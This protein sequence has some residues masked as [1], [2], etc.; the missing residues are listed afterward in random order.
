M[1]YY[2]VNLLWGLKHYQMLRFVLVKWNGLTSILATTDLT[3]KPITVIELYARRAKIESM[4]QEMK[5]QLGGFRYH[6]WTSSMPKLN[7]Y[8][9]KDSPDSLTGVK[10]PQSRKRILDCIMA[11]ENFVTCVTV[12]M[13]I[14]QLLSMQE[15]SNGS[16]RKLRYL[17]T[18]S[19]MKPSEG[20]V[21]YYIR[22]NLF[23]MLLLHP[24]SF[25]TRFIRERQGEPSETELDLES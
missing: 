24:N 25:I 8:A 3:M 7:H 15:Y 19:K 23:S 12:A 22:R 11:T 20:T 17:R 4:F 2:C 6:F 1:E 18:P 10:C 16:I 13:G 9:R 21:M 14:V 5:Q